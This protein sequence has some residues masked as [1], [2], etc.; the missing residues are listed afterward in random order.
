MDHKKI[1]APRTTITRNFNELDAAT[2][3]LYEAVALISRR[4][5]QINDDLRAELQD[6]LQEFATHVES[7]EEVFE[8]KEQIEVSKFYESLPKPVNMATQEWLE[9]KIYYRYPESEESTQP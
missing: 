6:K 3:N 4:A 9:G 5:E 8:N 1:N 7:L 2:D